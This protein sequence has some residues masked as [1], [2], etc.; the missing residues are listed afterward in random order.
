MGP[1][2]AAA[3]T[4]KA[5]NKKPTN[6]FSVMMASAR[7]GS[8][9]APAKGKSK[10]KEKAPSSFLGASVKASKSFVAASLS[11][12][13]GKEKS[14]DAEERKPSVKAKMRPR[15]KPKPLP[16]PLPL[17]V[18]E[19]DDADT[20]SPPET[21][22]FAKESDESHPE[23]PSDNM[24]MDVEPPFPSAV[25]GESS[26]DEN[27]DNTPMPPPSSS[28]VADDLE[29]SLDPQFPEQTQDLAEEEWET[30]V[31]SR[32][33]STTLLREKIT[34]V[35]SQKDDRVIVNKT[36]IRPQSRVGKSRMPVSIASA[37]G[38][39]TRSV[40][41]K[42]KEV[43][44]GGMLL[45]SFDSLLSSHILLLAPS[46]GSTGN[47]PLSTA[48][49]QKTEVSDTEGPPLSTSSLT[50][51]PGDS[52][53][54]RQGSPIKGGA[55]FARPTKSSAARAAVQTPAK[56]AKP[57]GMSTAG[58]PASPSKNKLVRAASLF[59]ANPASQSLLI[60][61]PSFGTDDRQNNSCFSS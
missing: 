29:P 57:V 50:D 21:P 43:E 4:S 51:P 13:K 48:K 30:P 11:N 41:L 7:S 32:S 53:P 8:I 40:S 23:A 56:S 9:P 42:R 19:D 36:N 55:S 14:K 61:F 54:S 6:A 33:S 26:I 45:G 15:E 16:L 2:A 58:D 35:V 1:P 52:L 47:K 38:R 60:V 31:D 28:P 34:P 3:E 24:V 37:S 27:V 39:V 44:D 49:R 22:I 5:A 18:Q 12:S 46:L 25:E 10:G 17:L 20:A 59:T